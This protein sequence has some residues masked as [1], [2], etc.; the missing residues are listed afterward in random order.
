MPP[1]LSVISNAQEKESEFYSS[2]LIQLATIGLDNT[3]KVRTVVFRGW[4]NLYEMMILTDKRSQKYYEL[5]TNNNVEVCWFFLKSKCQFRLRGISNFDH[6]NDTIQ[7][8]DKLDDQTKSMWNWPIP[9]NRF[10]NNP[11]E[12]KSL[13]KNSDILNNFILIKVS[14]RHV[15][16]LILEKPFHIRKQWSIT[17]QWLEERINP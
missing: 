10:E 7:H 17:N 4:T 1:W 8:W 12:A 15:D 11:S 13:N 9:G 2:R 16:Q 6:S 14:I 5:M 3:P